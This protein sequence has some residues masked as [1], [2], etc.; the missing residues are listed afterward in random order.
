MLRL[1]AEAME[2]LSKDSPSSEV[3]EY[4]TKDFVKTLEVNDELVQHR[5][6]FHLGIKIIHCSLGKIALKVASDFSNDCC[7]AR[8][9]VLV[10]PYFVVCRLT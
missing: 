7:V 6:K 3:V 2:E 10:T 5:P 4:K 1:A 9:L 8:A